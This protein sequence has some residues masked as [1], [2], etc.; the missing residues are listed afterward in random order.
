[1]ASPLL[2]LSLGALAGLG[3]AIQVSPASGPVCL[4]AATVLAI[5]WAIRRT[6]PGSLDFLGWVH[7]GLLGATLGQWRMDALVEGP[8]WRGPVA[9]D[10]T[11]VS[12][13]G[14][15]EADVDVDDRPGHH[16]LG[17]V[18][19]RFPTYAPAL[20]ASLRIEG[21]ARNWTR[22]ALPGGPDPV[23]LARLGGIRT[24]VDAREDPPRP[25]AHSTGSN[26]DPLSQALLTGRRADVDDNVTDTLRK[27]GTSH[28]L[29]VSGFHVATIAALAAAV[30]RAPLHA[31]AILR[32]VG[33]PPAIVA[34]LAAAAGAA[35][36][37]AVGAPV[38]AQRAAL[39]FAVIHLGRS[40][41]REPDP[42]TVLV[43]AAAFLAVNEPA[44]LGTPSFQLSFS[45][46]AGILQLTPALLRFLPPDT[47]FWCRWPIQALAVSA[48]ATL[49]TLPIS[50]WWFQ[51]LAPTSAVA[52]LVALP[53]ASLWIVP[54]AAASVAP[55]PVG[56]AMAGL[57]GAG[58]DV[59]LAIL[60]PL[61][62]EPVH[63][64]VS[65]W[66]VGLLLLPLWAPRR[67]ILALGL[68]LLGLGAR[69]R[70]AAGL[71]V[72]QFDVGQGDAVAV[73]F[74]DGRTWLV[75]GGP[76]GDAVVQWLRRRGL[77]R[78]DAVVATHP[79]R[80]HEGGLH[81]VIETL[82]VRRLWRPDPMRIDTLS[83]AAAEAGISVLF[84]PHALW[85]PPGFLSQDP[86]ESSLVLLIESRG[87]RVL[88]TGDAPS[89]TER[90]W[91]PDLPRIDLLKVGHHGSRHSTGPELLN[92]TRPALAT[93]G[94]GRT[95][96]YGHPTA[97]VLDRLDQA[98]V[99]VLRTD[100]D[101]TIEVTMVPNDL[102][103]RTMAPGRSNIDGRQTDEY[104]DPTVRS[105]QD[106]RRRDRR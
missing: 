5:L 3:A 102:T 75:D 13:A 48:G 1:M 76:P 96:R 90:H 62:A 65:G 35:Y 61:A 81:P 20:G 51:E 8:V 6:G 67:H 36:A 10:G 68:T 33:V 41:G 30:L 22:T 26:L 93:I 42:L 57:A 72:T 54:A 66:G 59:L 91:A 83:Q 56:D 23:A 27:T 12:V 39:T 87:V 89:T 99:H 70:L 101:G 95:N 24:W 55:N 46:V 29:S 4:A 97:E 47:P 25:L 52:N 98:G 31:L 88:L 43:L 86:N 45:A 37:W 103:W 49:G 50:A 84:P 80:D 74:A 40:H 71:R 2:P 19:V 16:E 11:V 18:R 17:R 92:A 78:L 106:L 9:F 64:A 82:Q 32:P 21:N 34:W 79:Q 63:P 73:E 69:P 14:S 94:V 77:T 28:L 85:P 15:R 44:V 104:H 7:L 53:L 58:V 60:R 38:T 105:T 100:R